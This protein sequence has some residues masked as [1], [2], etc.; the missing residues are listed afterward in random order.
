MADDTLAIDRA[1]E[2]AVRHTFQARVGRIELR[3]H[4]PGGLFQEDALAIQLSVLQVGDHETSHVGRCSAQRTRRVVQC[5]L[6]SA[7]EVGVGGPVAGR[8]V[9]SQVRRQRLAEGAARHAQRHEN[10]PFHVFIKRQARDALD[11]VPRQGSA[12]IGVDSYFARRENARRQIVFHPVAQQDHLPG[13][14]PPQVGPFLLETGRMAQQ[15]AQGNRLGEGGRDRKVQV[16]VDIS[17]Q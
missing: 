5:E 10:V 13:L 12:I 8:H 9:R 4:L 7:F 1:L 3:V 17:I 2:K 14:Q 15:V 16:F 6:E 11:S